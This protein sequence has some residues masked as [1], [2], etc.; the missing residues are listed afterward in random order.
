MFG[1]TYERCR[2][3]NSS[4]M[5]WLPLRWHCRGFACVLCCAVL[6]C[7]VLQGEGGR[8]GESTFCVRAVLIWARTVACLPS[9]I[10]CLLYLLPDAHCFVVLANLGTSHAPLCKCRQELRSEAE[11]RHCLVVNVML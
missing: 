9:Y 4:F 11:E 2:A 1:C 10:F 8:E 6:Y 3:V 5:D 7:A